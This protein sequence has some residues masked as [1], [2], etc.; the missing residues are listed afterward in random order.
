MTDA[1]ALLAAAG[2]AVL[3]VSPGEPGAWTFLWIA[4]AIQAVGVGAFFLGRGVSARRVFAYAVAFRLIGVAGGPFLED[5]WF[6]YLWDGYRFAEDGTPYG[7]P[8]EAWFGDPDV[9][10]DFRMLLDQVN[11]PELPTIYGPTAQVAFLAAHL[12]TP[13]RILGLQILLAVFDLLLVVLLLKLAPARAVLLYAFSPL[14]VKEIAFTAH[15][16]GLAVCLLFAA[17]LL[18]RRRWFLG[19]GGALALAVGAKALALALVPFVLIRAPLRAWIAFGAALGL[20]YLPFALKGATDLGT[21][22]VFVQEWRFNA[23]VFAAFEGVVPDSALRALWAVSFLAVFAVLLARHRRDPDAL[24]RGDWLYG[25]LLVLGPVVNPWY[26]LFVLPFAVARPSLWAW[27]ASG[28]VLASYLTGLN[29]NDLSLHPFGHPAWVLPVEYGLIALAA[30]IDWRR[31]RTR[32]RPACAKGA[33]AP[34]A[35]GR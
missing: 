14:V 18:A 15:P 30:V 19:A 10:E 24:P 3:A 35:R 8:P 22:G 6:R 25:A 33:P 21:L 32:S 11:Y 23:P 20:L 1:A 28:A 13:A 7:S 29:L 17:I 5:D 31:S 26:L 34:E 27:T 12:M 16:D 9:P 2:F 4:L